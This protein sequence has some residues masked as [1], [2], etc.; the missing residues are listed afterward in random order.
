MGIPE[1]GPLRRL[2]DR[3]QQT[4]PAAAPFA[5][6][7]GVLHALSASVVAVFAPP[8]ENAEGILA[9]PFPFQNALDNQ[10]QL[11]YYFLSTSLGSNSEYSL[12]GGAGGIPTDPGFAATNARRTTLVVTVGTGSLLERYP[13]GSPNPFTGRAPVIRCAEVLRCLAKVRVRT[14]HSVGPASPGP[15]Q[16]RTRPL[17]PDQNVYHRQLCRGQRHGRRYSAGAPHRLLGRRFRH[18]DIM[19][20]NAAIPGKDSVPAIPNTCHQ[21]YVAQSPLPNWP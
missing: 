13:T 19:R 3:S 7:C 4:D 17:E 20:L 14:T 18:V 15:A 6:P 11:A 8:Q 5:A 12:N 9:F 21:L 2:D 16:R 1:H 10:N